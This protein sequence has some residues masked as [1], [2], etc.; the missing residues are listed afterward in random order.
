MENK[1]GMDEAIRQVKAIAFPPTAEVGQNYNAKVKNIVAFGAFCEILPGVDALLHVSEIAWER[2]EKVEEK[3]K[4]GDECTEISYDLRL[5]FKADLLAN[6]PSINCGSTK[7]SCLHIPL[8]KALSLESQYYP[9]LF[10]RE[11]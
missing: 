2:V 5:L 11:T 3:L 4:V 6:L 7:M 9:T 10:S 1:E 8:N